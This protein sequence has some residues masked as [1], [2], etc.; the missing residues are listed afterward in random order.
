MRENVRDNSYDKMIKTPVEKLVL[1]LAVPSIITM[2]ISNI[3][4]LVDTA[5][6][7]KL[8]NSAS[9]AIGIVFGFMAIL[10]AIGFLFGQGGGSIISR[11]LG[12]RDNDRASVTASVSFFSAFLVAVITAVVCFIFLDPLVMLLGSTKTIAPYAKTYIEY[13]LLAAP[14][15]ITSFTLNNILR[16]EGRAMLGMIGM[17]S[18]AI[19]NIAGDAFLM[20][21]LGLGIEGA[22]IS[23]AVSQVVSF[24]ILISVFASGKTSTKISLKLYIDALRRRVKT[25]N[26]IFGAVLLE[27]LATGL[28]SLIRQALSSVAVVIQNSEAGAYG[29]EAVAAISIVSRISFFVFSISLGIGQ[30]FQPVGGFNYGAKK[31]GRLRKGYRFTVISSTIIIVV[32]SAICYVMAGDLIGIFRDDATVIRIGT[33]ALRLLCVAHLFVPFC[34]ATEMLM[35]CTGKKL[36]ASILSATRNGLIFI[37]GILVL[38]RLRGLNGVIEAQPLAFVLSIIPGIIFAVAFFRTLGGE[39]DEAQKYINSGK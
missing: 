17:M 18:G 2:L 34:M 25:A 5:F 31:Y 16:Y 38:S 4:N 20:R 6:V 8:G 11:Q 22:G 27:V 21:V 7:G 19:L 24:C 28:P 37:P 26:V 39:N 23:T 29:D 12:A 36:W 9:G 1:T 32:L 15:L 30:G 13:I 35:Q 3:Y 33:R 14:F 10:Q